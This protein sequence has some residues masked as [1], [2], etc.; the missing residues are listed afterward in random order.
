MVETEKVV[1]SR[2]FTPTCAEG[3]RPILCITKE[4]KVSAEPT[5]S[6]EEGAIVNKSST[7]EMMKAIIDPGSAT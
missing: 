4:V 3:G 5:S 6:K 2:I 1:T 7:Y